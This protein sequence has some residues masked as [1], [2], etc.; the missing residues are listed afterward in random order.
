MGIWHPDRFTPM[1]QPKRMTGVLKEFEY[2]YEV[3]NILSHKGTNNLINSKNELIQR[4]EKIYVFHD[5]SGK[6]SECRWI[7]DGRSEL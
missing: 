4:E 3:E 5:S 1:K 7:D 2:F 6:E